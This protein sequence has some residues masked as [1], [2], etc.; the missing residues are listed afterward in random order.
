MRAIQILDADRT[1]SLEQD[2]R[3]QRVFLDHQPGRQLAL[4]AEEEVARAVPLS[5]QNGERSRRQALGTVGE[6]SGIVR[7]EQGGGKPKWIADAFLQRLMNGLQDD[8][9]DFRIAQRQFA[10]FASLVPSHPS[11][12]WPCPKS[13]QPGLPAKR[14]A[15]ADS[16]SASP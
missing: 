8:L 7:I 3:R 13:F 14:P 5:R 6:V 11:K 2:L 10:G 4:R 1:P 15:T 12:P 16:T 9:D